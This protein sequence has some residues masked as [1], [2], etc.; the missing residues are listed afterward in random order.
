MKTVFKTGELA[1]I[2]ANQSAEDLANNREGRCT[3]SMSFRGRDFYSYRTVIARLLE[4]GSVVVATCSYSSTTVKHQGYVRQAVRHLKCHNIE[5]FD[6]AEA[7]I[8]STNNRIKELHKKASTAKSKRDSYLADAYNLA[9]DLNVYLDA[10]KHN[11][12]YRVAVP[13]N[14]DLEAVK[15]AVKK[16]QA[17]KLARRNAR[18]AQREAYLKEELDAWLA[19]QDVNTWLLR[20]LGVKLRVKDN[21]VETTHGARV[22]LE[23]SLKMW[24]VMTACTTDTQRRRLHGHKI[25]HYMVNT[26]T[27]DRL[28]I[29]CHQIPMS[30]VERIAVQLGVAA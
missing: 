7:L 28:T 12:K 14:V 27:K 2:W 24:G 29:G 30:E 18:Q 10:I 8:D 19:G 4:D 26:F 6:Y 1:H 9:V 22:P 21:V 16:Q 3:S 11:P 17:E 13:E 15:V 5:K 20:E 23:D 25:G